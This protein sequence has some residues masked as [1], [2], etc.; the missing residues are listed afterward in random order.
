M[1]VL[2]FNGLPIQAG[3]V[4]I[5]NGAILTSQ[6]TST[7]GT[8]P[9]QMT[10]TGALTIDSTSKIDVTG[11]GYPGGFPTG[12]TFG[13]TTVGGATDA[14]SYGGLG[15][16][17]SGLSTNALY[18]D[19]N[20]PNDV[21]SGGAGDRGTGG[22]GGGLVR[23]T[24]ASAQIDGSILADGIAGFYDGYRIGSGGS[25]GGISLNFGTLAGAGKIRRR[26]WCR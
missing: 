17:Y 20:D 8:F 23:I 19:P 13:N 21:G 24:A 22:A 12:T 7:L 16:V 10:L 4:S 11:L 15:G 6:P 2:P 3:N 9:L 14:G 18:G 26:W 5:L 1:V 25:G